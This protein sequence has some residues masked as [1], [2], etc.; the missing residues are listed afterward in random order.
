T[1]RVPGTHFISVLLFS[2][3]GSL[4]VVA[5]I[6]DLLNITYRVRLVNNFLFLSVRRVT[7]KR[8]VDNYTPLF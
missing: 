8:N 6:S 4:I 3:Q 1:G 7:W 2:F 5:L